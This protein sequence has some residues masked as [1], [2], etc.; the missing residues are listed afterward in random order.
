MTTNTEASR[1]RAAVLTP[2]LPE[3][4]KVCRG[5]VCC[6][7]QTGSRC[8]NSAKDQRTRAA[9]IGNDDNCKSEHTDLQPHEQTRKRIGSQK[10]RRTHNSTRHPPMLDVPPEQG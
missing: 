9:T 5:R 3:A 2:P 1:R 8:A 4:G 6:I 10:I 7:R